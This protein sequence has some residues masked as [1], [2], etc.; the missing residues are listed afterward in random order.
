MARGKT[1]KRNPCQPASR[2]GFFQEQC[3]FLNCDRHDIV[4]FVVSGGFIYLD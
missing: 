1:L 3:Q 4:V 2:R